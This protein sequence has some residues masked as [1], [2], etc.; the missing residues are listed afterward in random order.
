MNVPVDHRHIS[1]RDA[2]N[3]HHIGK[4]VLWSGLCDEVTFRL[5]SEDQ[6]LPWWLSGK[7]PSCQCRRCGFDPWVRKI[8]WRRK[9]QPTAVFFPGKSHG[10]RSLAGYSPWGHK[11]LDTTWWINNNWRPSTSQLLRDHGEGQLE[12]EQSVR[13]QVPQWENWV[14]ESVPTKATSRCVLT[15]LTC[16][17]DDVWCLVEAHAGWLQFGNSSEISALIVGSEFHRTY[18]RVL[19]VQSCVLS[20]SISKQPASSDDSL[21]CVLFKRACWVGSALALS[22]LSPLR[23]N[24]PVIKLPHFN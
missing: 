16:P 20:N 8:P 12:G 15:F 10:Q 5:R 17:H 22:P 2:E 9:W 13:A 6:G 18:S 4:L 23:T 3:S 11:E 21:G 19:C 7:E 14:K 1:Y 24:L